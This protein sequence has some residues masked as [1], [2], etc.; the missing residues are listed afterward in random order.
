M[1]S[2]RA[3]F[4]RVRAILLRRSHSDTLDAE[5]EAHLDLLSADYV[6]LGLS[7][8]DARV[9]ARRDFGGVTQVKE[10]YRD[11]QRWAIVT[12]VVRDLRHGLR[13]LC[14]SPGFT[15]AAVLTLALGIAANAA[16]FGLV[17]P[18]LFRPLP[19]R[20]AE[21]LTVFARHQ[22]DGN[23][24][25][26]FSSAEFDTL[27]TQAS[28]WSNLVAVAPGMYGLTADG[29][30]DRVAVS[31]VSE[32]YWDAFGLQA[33][34][35]ALFRPTDAEL[36]TAAPVIVLSDEY[37]RTRFDRSPSAVG[38][39]ISL[40]GVP[41]T[42]V[43]V[44]PQGFRGDS[45]F[46]DVKAF[47]P[48]HA[49][50]FHAASRPS[51]VLGFLK[52]GF[53]LDQANAS[54]GAM[55]DAMARDRREV[56]KDVRL[57][58]S[59]ERFS[60]PS[61]H[62]ARPEIATALIFGFLASFVLALSCVNVSSLILIRAAARRTEMAL[63][64]ALG[65]SRPRLALHL[66]IETLLL[67]T[68]AGIAG[69]VLGDG[70]T[71]AL[72][73]LLPRFLAPFTGE[74]GFGFDWRVA[75]FTVMVIC[76][77]TIAVGMVPALRATRTSLEALHHNGPTATQGRTRLRRGLMM[78]QVAGALMLLTVAGLF[79]RSL[80]A[81]RV[82]P[83]GFD[84]RGV[85]DFG[86]NPAEIGDVGN[87]AQDRLKAVLAAVTVLPGVDAA[88]LTQSVPMT[89]ENYSEAQVYGEGLPLAA[90][91][92]QEVGYSSVS[93]TYF[94]TLRIPL[95]DGRPFSSADTSTAP[96]VAIVNAAMANRYWPNGNALGRRFRLNSE[97]A[98]AVDVV[99][100]A[101]NILNYS[102]MQ[103]EA[104]PFFYLPLEQHPTPSV[105]LHVRSERPAATMFRDVNAA[106]RTVA[107]DI[108]PF[109]VQTMADAIEAAPDGLLLPRLGAWLAMSFALLGLVLAVVGVYGVIAY[110]A[111][112]RAREMALRIALG[113]GPQ[114]IRR[115]VLKSGLGVVAGGLVLGLGLAAT[116]AR[117][118]ANLYFG[119]SALDPAT[120]A[121]A[122]LVVG[123]TA[124]VAC[125]VPARRAMRVD[126]VS[127]LK[128]A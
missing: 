73:R 35:G 95:R 42:I 72:G 34:F 53:T 22:K 102:V 4:A 81:T 59:W 12:H 91:K 41:L 51:R 122:V 108:V 107:P 123:G 109:N 46:M 74:L 39:H 33:S 117:L 48:L 67:V 125:Y 49:P 119:V 110:G 5:I 10:A 8:A 27:R 87:V 30:T 23:T 111:S 3:V 44:G 19:V 118:T 32:N 82:L 89:S 37:W 66:L 38:K 52:P 71:I 92:I 16:I 106:V 114:D 103:D 9:A 45:I 69:L 31:F 61:P 14:R 96:R 93:P 60:R 17:N 57:M 43:G 97:S 94:E 90:P 20:D 26:T 54:L 127:A 124:F 7:A 29:L 36:Q 15:T 2:L 77:T 24:V 62:T 50:G 13:G 58:A 128:D 116:F 100:V 68:A 88:T 113:A 28:R 47:V 18:L 70:L 86:L 84:R 75:A 120:F 56:P 112:Q 121:T 63:R 98:P 105:T 78:L 80:A 101:A 104:T 55:S 76:L 40:G 115:E 79:A 1:T 83:F 25:T 85:S 21:R 11:T 99:G 64:T 65:A 6:R 126:P